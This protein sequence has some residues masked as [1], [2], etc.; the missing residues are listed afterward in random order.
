MIPA[1]VTP[2]TVALAAPT[3]IGLEQALI[4]ALKAQNR[5]QAEIIF[6]HPQANTISPECLGEALVITIQKNIFGHCGHAILNLPNAND[7]PEEDFGHAVLMAIHR[8]DLDALQ[9]LQRRQPVKFNAM[10]TEAEYGLGQA[11]LSEIMHL[12]H[13]YDN[14]PNT[15]PVDVEIKFLEIIVNHP[16]T[17]LIEIEVPKLEGMDDIEFEENEY[18]IVQSDGMDNLSIHLGKLLRHIVIDHEYENSRL[19]AQ[20]LMLPAVA[21]LFEPNSAF[22]LGRALVHAAYHSNNIF[23][24]LILAHPMAV[25]ISSGP[26]QIPHF[27]TDMERNYPNLKN[28][29]LTEAV[30]F[31]IS[32]EDQDEAEI[33]TMVTDILGFARKNPVPDLHKGGDFGLKRA[34]DLAIIKGYQEVARCIQEFIDTE[35]D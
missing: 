32:N 25:Q 11:L 23:V 10:N 12:N 31:T 21:R 13:I 24:R 35:I 34:H 18:E 6:T 33:K 1:M 4:A 8:R 3:N 5:N 14:V 17:R 26:V 27:R 15:D 2:Q 7:I 9:H 22:G 19:I 16:N 30:F 28:F 20:L 29:G